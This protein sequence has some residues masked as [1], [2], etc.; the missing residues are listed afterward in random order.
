MARPMQKERL[1]SPHTPLIVENQAFGVVIFGQLGQNS[2]FGHFGH[3]FPRQDGPPE[4]KLHLESGLIQQDE[5][6]HG[7]DGFR[8]TTAPR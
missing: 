1:K 7:G 6:T 8:S 3:P 5:A 2:H 4:R